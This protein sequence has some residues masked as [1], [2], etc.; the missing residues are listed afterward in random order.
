MHRSRGLEQ[1]SQFDGQC[2]T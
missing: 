2:K 1:I